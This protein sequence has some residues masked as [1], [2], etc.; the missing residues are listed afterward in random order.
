MMVTIYATSGGGM[1]F[2]T[3][4]A[5]S[6]TVNG[7]TNTA[8]E[9]RANEAAPMAKPVDEFYPY[10]YE[11]PPPTS[12]ATT[13]GTGTSAVPA[14]TRRT[15]KRT[16]DRNS[17]APLL[18]VRNGATALITL[19]RP[20]VFNAVDLSMAT[21]LKTSLEEASQDRRVRAVILTGAGRGFC[22][23]GDLRFAVDAN[24]AQPGESFLALTAILHA[25]IA[26]IRTMA[27]PV[28]AAINGPAAGAGLFLALACDLRVMAHGAYLKQSNTSYGLS[29]PAGGTFLLPRLLGLGQ[30]LQIA[31]LDEPIFAAQA[32]DLGLVTKVVPDATLLSAAQQFAEQTAHRSGDALGR[33]KQLM[34]SAFYHTLEEHLHLERQAIAASANTAEGREGVTAFL[35]KRQ[36]DFV[37]AV[38]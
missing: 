22:A 36:P 38:T 9:P 17:S 2:A 28:I 5:S 21:L 24:P 1:V 10:W 34:N 14:A 37:T 13:A 25:A 15:P 7:A 35:E 4:D 23:G 18:Y 33:T 32:L 31:M 19:N 26:Q 6:S 8:S 20:A 27:K 11:M 29:I 3:E 12:G 16:P 30:A